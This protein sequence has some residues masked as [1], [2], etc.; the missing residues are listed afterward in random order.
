[1]HN[2][3]VKLWRKVRDCGIIG[4]P[5]AVSLFFYAM[6]TATSK[7][8]KVVVKGTVLEIG[9]GELIIAVRE[10]SKVLGMT[11]QNLRTALAMLEK[12]EILTRRPTHHCTIIKL[13][14]WHVYQAKDSQANTP[15]NTD[16]T[17]TQHRLNTDLTQEQ[18]VKKLRREER[19]E[20]KEVNP[21][22]I[23]GEA[24]EPPSPP[25]EPVVIT[26]TALK[27][28]IYPVTQK[29][30][31]EWKDAFPALDIIATIK[32]ARVW[33]EANP[34]KRKTLKGMKAFLVNWFS[35][36]QNRGGKPAKPYA[37]AWRGTEEHD[38]DR[39]YEF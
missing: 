23:C 14:K 22:D 16:P 13:V 29:Q 8:R 25:T 18:E 37:G 5:N 11:E 35:R 39:Q 20:F 38:G 32:Q 7:P 12:L 19:E 2:G 15:D 30:V 17:Q 3:Y 9:E 4:H 34:A 28:E 26:L 21:K 36:E 33:M 31:D 10:T 27:G 1:M 24:D 6:I